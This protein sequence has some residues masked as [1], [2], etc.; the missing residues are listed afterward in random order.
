M[1]KLIPAMK[2]DDLTP[3]E[4]KQKKTEIDKLKA[5]RKPESWPTD[6]LYWDPAT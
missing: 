3:D 1:D 4:R 2:D 5:M 6:V